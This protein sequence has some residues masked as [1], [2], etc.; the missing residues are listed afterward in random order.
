MEKKHVKG[1]CTDDKSTEA[2]MEKRREFIKKY[3]KL[4]AVTPIALS[5][6]MHSKAQIGS[7]DGGG[8]DGGPF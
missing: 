6:A 1:H 3:G 2:I 7:D 4:A 8:G 5:L